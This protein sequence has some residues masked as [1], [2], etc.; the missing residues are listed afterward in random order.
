MWGGGLSIGIGLLIGNSVIRMFYPGSPLLRR[1]DIYGGL[2][3]F[4]CF[5]LYDT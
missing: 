2:A 5:V 3:L 1:I 4:G